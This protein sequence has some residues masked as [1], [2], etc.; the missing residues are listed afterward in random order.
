MLVKQMLGRYSKN[1]LMCQTNMDLTL[2]L[3]SKSD[4]IEKV[5]KQQMATQL[6]TSIINGSHTTWRVKPPTPE[7]Y[8]K[9]YE[10]Q[11]FVFHPDDFQKLIKDVFD[12]GVEAAKAEEK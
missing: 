12:A 6:A 10:M 4:D 1:R 9:S 3:N 5:L 2:I 7:Q 8:G 11:S